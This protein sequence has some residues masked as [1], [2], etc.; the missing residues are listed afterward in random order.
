M[1]LLF[2]CNN[3]VREIIPD[4]HPAFPGIPI[5]Q[6]YPAALVAEMRHVDDSVEVGEGYRYD[7][8]TGTWAYTERVPEPA[9][10][11]VEPRVTWSELAAAITEGV[12]SV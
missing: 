11:P 12:E 1:Y 8:E 2:D 10:A 6:R 9:P 5:E 4:E 3:R 7:E